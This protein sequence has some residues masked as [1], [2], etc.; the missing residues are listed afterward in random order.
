MF[1]KEVIECWNCYKL[2]HYQYECPD[3]EK[4]ANFVEL[5]KTDEVLLMV[6]VEDN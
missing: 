4:K 1:N 5:D 3:M 6:Y 2:G